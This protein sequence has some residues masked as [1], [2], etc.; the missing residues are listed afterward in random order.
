MRAFLIIDTE[1][2]RKEIEVTNSQVKSLTPIIKKIN[3]NQ[4]DY[5]SYDSFELFQQL[6]TSHEIDDEDITSINIHYHS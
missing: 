6:L 4:S 3:K 2:Y 5:R 1:D